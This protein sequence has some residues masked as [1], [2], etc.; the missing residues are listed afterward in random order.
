MRFK[1]NGPI[2]I[3][4]N[5]IVALSTS[6][7]KMNLDISLSRTLKAAESATE[8]GSRYILRMILALFIIVTLNLL[9]VFA[10]F[11]LSSLLLANFLLGSLLIFTLYTFGQTL[12]KH[13]TFWIFRLHIWLLRSGLVEVNFD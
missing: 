13:M 9:L 6:G 3:S 11:D 5:R 10:H 7:A 8:S 12:D 4:E 2:L 1:A